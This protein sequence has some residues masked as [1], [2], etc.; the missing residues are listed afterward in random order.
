MGEF[1][2]GRRDGQGKMTYPAG[3]VYEGQWKIDKFHG[4]G[5]LTY[6]NGSVK[7]GDYLYNKFKGI[8]DGPRKNG[9]PDGPGHIFNNDGSYYKGYF[10]RGWRR[11]WGEFNDKYKNITNSI[12]ILNKKDSLTITHYNNHPSIVKEETNYIKGNKFGKSKI[13]F[14]NGDIIE[15]NYFMNKLYEPSNCVKGDCINGY[16]EID[17]MDGDVTYKGEF[18][19]GLPHGKGIFEVND[20]LFYDGEW[21][22]GYSHG[23][24]KYKRK[25]EYEGEF[26]Y[27]KYHGKGKLIKKNLDGEIEKIEEGQFEYGHFI[28]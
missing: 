26:K 9:L 16:G 11:G 4:L 28:G 6:A 1:K 10:F 25:N 7:E 3:S 12:R 22:N 23:Y 24:G 8:Y 2:N 13:T 19:D 17:I 14:K 5:K 15:E 27:S 18:K 21:E 20:G